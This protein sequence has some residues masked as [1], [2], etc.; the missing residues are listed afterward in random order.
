M[1]NKITTVV[2]FC[3]IVSN[4][5]LPQTEKIGIRSFWS[6]TAQLWIFFI[7][8]NIYM[9]WMLSGVGNEF[10]KKKKKKKVETLWLVNILKTEF[11]LMVKV[12]IHEKLLIYNWRKL[13]NWSWFFF[14]TGSENQDKTWAEDMI[15]VISHF[16]ERFI[17]IIVEVNE[18]CRLHKCLL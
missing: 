9:S 11:L 8:K 2:W 6:K 5:K 18:T 10:L 7:T 12:S 14:L 13:F 4:C 1:A 3:S 15:R 16:T 17:I